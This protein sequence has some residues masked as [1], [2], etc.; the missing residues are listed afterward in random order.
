MLTKDQRQKLI[1]RV[2]MNGHILMQA[3]NAPISDLMQLHASIRLMAEDA[4]TLAALLSTSLPAAEGEH[5]A[6]IERVRENDAARKAI[7]APACNDTRICYLHRV[8]SDDAL[9][10]ATLLDR[11]M[12]DLEASD[13]ALLWI[14]DNADWTEPPAPQN[15]A[16]AIEAARTRAV[17]E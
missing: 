8:A 11:A 6:L 7:K 5:K 4:L 3:T 14:E 10:L 9:A 13:K 17:K 16:T 15:V 12:K 2:Q 1:H